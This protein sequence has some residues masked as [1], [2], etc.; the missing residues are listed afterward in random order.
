MWGWPGYYDP[1]WSDWR[2]VQF[3]GNGGYYGGGGWRSSAWASRFGRVKTGVEP[4]E[5]EVWLNGKYIGTADDFDGFPDYLYLEPGSYKLEFRLGGYETWASDAN[6]RRGEAVRL[7]HELT[8]EKGHGRLD[9]FLPPSKGVPDGRYFDKSGQPTRPV[10]R[11]VR[12][13]VRTS[14]GE[15]GPVGADEKKP[16]TDVEAESR[17]E[18]DDEP[19]DVDVDVDK[20]PARER[21]VV[22]ETPRE[23]AK[24]EPAPRARLRWKVTP[25]DAAVWVDDKY[26]GTA[27]ELSARP[28]GTLMAPGKHT[29][30]VVRPGYESR[31]VTVEAE[32][33]EA[34][35]VVV[36]L[37]K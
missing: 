10:E 33:G 5:A 16:R 28:R 6:V 1:F 12:V 29:V 21:E 20:S 30:T 37:E 32:A 17:D 14:E 8:R 2:Y 23:V 11:R 15:E 22:R 7:D 3:Y 13:T 25:D 27:D 26:L 34:V 24:D 19:A 9:S 4:D 35:D 31:T 36:E 18:D